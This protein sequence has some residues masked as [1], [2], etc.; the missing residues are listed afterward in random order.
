MFRRHWPTP[1]KDEIV[2]L[3]KLLVI[4]DQNF[5]YLPL[6]EKERTRLSSGTMRRTSSA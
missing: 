1:T 4:D 2:R 3:S 5:D 6:F